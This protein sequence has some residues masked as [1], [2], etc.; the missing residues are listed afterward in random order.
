MKKLIL[1]AIAS[2]FVGCA[3]SRHTESSDELIVRDLYVED[4]S[5]PGTFISAPDTLILTVKC[6]YKNNKVSYKIKHK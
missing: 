5:R 6:N 2:L 1:I 3:T 4:A